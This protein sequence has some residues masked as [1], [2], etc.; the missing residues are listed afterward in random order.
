MKR[1]ENK[2]WVYN[3]DGYRWYPPISE[4]SAIHSL[5]G[6]SKEKTVNVNDSSFSMIPIPTAAPY[7]ANY[8]LRGDL[9]PKCSWKTDYL[10]SC[11]NSLV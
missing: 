8:S 7:I 4:S 5:A 9:S 2:S 6:G 11:E 3:F 10:F 1:F